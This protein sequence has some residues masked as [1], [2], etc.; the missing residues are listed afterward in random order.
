MRNSSEIYW[1]VFNSLIMEWKSFNTKCVLWFA[2]NH[3]IYGIRIVE[4]FILCILLTDLRAWVVNLD[5][6]FIE[7]QGLV[8]F[9]WGKI[10][11]FAFW[12]GFW[13]F[14]YL[15]DVIL[16]VTSAWKTHPQSSYNTSLRFEKKSC[17]KLNWN[18]E[19]KSDSKI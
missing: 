15:I 13:C 17:H 7:F 12:K 1:N 2:A 10:D 11:E 16:E 5:K 9:Y 3:G 14:K 8:T 19:N 6:C 4:S 18:S